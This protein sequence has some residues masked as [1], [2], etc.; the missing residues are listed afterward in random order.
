[1]RVKG[2]WG[3][4]SAARPE[5]ERGTPRWGGRICTWFFLF[6]AVTRVILPYPNK[7]LCKIQYFYVVLVYG[8]STPALIYPLASLSWPLAD[9]IQPLAKLEIT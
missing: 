3:R 7:V 6:V 9:L 4:R 5:G 1:M 8:A 2:G